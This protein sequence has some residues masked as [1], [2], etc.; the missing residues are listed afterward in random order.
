[1]PRDKG[2][3]RVAPAPDGRGMPDQ[4]KPP[5]PHRLPWFWIL[6]LIVLA[7]NWATVLMVK[8]AGQPRVNIPFSPYFL[9]Q[10]DAGTVKSISSKG[11]TIAGTFTQKVV[12]PPGSHDATPTTLFSTEVPT[13]WDNAALTAELQGKGVEINAESPTPGTSI[14]SEASARRCSSSASSGS[15]RA[16]HRPV[17]A[18]LGGSAH[19]AGRRH[20]ESTRPRSG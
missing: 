20:G 11:D 3:W 9:N 8:G 19:S 14:L 10:V 18:G 13:F 17:G 12:Y 6:L 1:M 16:G 15:S 4:H 2:R 5:P 7:I